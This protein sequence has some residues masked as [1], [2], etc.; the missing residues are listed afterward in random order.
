MRTT[1]H[2]AVFSPLN[3]QGHRSALTHIFRQLHARLACQI[4]FLEGRDG[5]Q[6]F[7]LE[8]IGCD[9]VIA[10]GGIAAPLMRTIRRLEIPCVIINPDGRVKPSPKLSFLQDDS[11]AIGRFAARY[12]LDRQYTSF[13]Y[14]D[15][16]RDIQWSNDRRT[17]F[18]E[19]LAQ[20]GYTCITHS[21]KGESARKNWTDERPQI[22]E[23]IRRLPRPTAVFAAMDGRARLVLDAC[24]EAGIRVPDEISVLGVDNDPTICASTEPS[25]SSIDMSDSAIGPCV[26][27]TL[28]SLM[29]GREAPPHT[30]GCRLK[31]ITR[32]STGYESM[33]DPFIAKALKHIDAHAGTESLTVSDVVAHLA[34][35]RRHLEILF[36]RKFGR[37]VHDQILN[38]KMKR[39]CELLTETNLTLGEIAA[40]TGFSRDSH[41]SRTFRNHFGTTMRE[42]RLHN[43]N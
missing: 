16:N 3:L 24:A 18:V 10:Y 4:Y 32:K 42:F 25:L 21:P 34:C 38:V 33:K 13:A 15:T 35:S 23:F 26:V 30:F 19:T 37:S 17:G 7:D 14:V 1:H 41:L 40:E 8:E 2:I 29:R 9:G 39:V 5:E 27:E 36:R 11:V 28:I 43:R 12:F 20:H 22:I 31:A 6:S